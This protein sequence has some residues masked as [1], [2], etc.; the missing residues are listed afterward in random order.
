MSILRIKLEQ[1]FSD[2]KKIKFKCFLYHTSIFKILNN[3]R[4]LILGSN[5]DPTPKIINESIYLKCIPIITDQIGV[6]DDLIKN[7]EL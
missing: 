2:N 5:Y 7:G 3:S 1:K 6:S 4:Y